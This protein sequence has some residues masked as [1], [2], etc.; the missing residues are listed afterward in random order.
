M[1]LRSLDT[2][3]SFLRRAAFGACLAAASVCGA[4]GCPQGSTSTNNNL[5]NC[6]SRL[7]LFDQAASAAIQASQA[8][9]AGN[10]CP[11]FCTKLQEMKDL[12]QELQDAGCFTGN[13]GQPELGAQ[14]Q[15]QVGQL[16]QMSG[17]ICS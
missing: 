17:G 5:T 6:V 15:A 3:G 12:L 14:L 16:E 9:G 7:D 13:S 2:P 8:C 1:L 10:A 4:G 11:D